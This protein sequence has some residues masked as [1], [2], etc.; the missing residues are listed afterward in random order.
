MFTEN[1]Y[2]EYQAYILKYITFMKI[3][4]IYDLNL[5]NV[6]IQNTSFGVRKNKEYIYIFSFVSLL[7]FFTNLISWRQPSGKEKQ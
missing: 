3:Y 4:I 6:I 7:P 2:F 1:K 5:I